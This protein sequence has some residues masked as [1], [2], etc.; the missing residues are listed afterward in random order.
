MQWRLPAVPRHLRQVGLRRLIGFR[1]P[2]D[3][4]II[5][6]LVH[7][8][9]N[10]LSLFFQ[11]YCFSW[12]YALEKGGQLKL[13]ALMQELFFNTIEPFPCFVLKIQ[14]TYQLDFAPQILLR[15]PLPI[16]HRLPVL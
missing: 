10:F 16:H 4:V 13:T 14:D 8:D 1:R 3:H 6:F 2:V 9:Y 7:F 5:L 12:F 15:V 11:E